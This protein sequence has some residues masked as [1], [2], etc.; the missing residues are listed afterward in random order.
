MGE[1][2][3][4]GCGYRLLPIADCW[5]IHSTLGISIN[6]VV[7]DDNSVPGRMLKKAGKRRPQ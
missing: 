4:I 3:R 6:S 2:R 1:A 7:S 5:K